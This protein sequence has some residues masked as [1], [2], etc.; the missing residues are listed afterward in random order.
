MTCR[1]YWF[2]C[3]IFLFSGSVW[4][5]EASE[6][7]EWTVESLELE[8]SSKKIYD[9][10]EEAQKDL[11]AQLVVGLSLDFN[12][13]RVSDEI[14]VSMGELKPILLQRIVDQPQKLVG[15]KFRSIYRMSNYAFDEWRFRSLLGPAYRKPSNDEIY[16]LLV[17]SFNLLDCPRFE[18][19]ERGPLIQAFQRVFHGELIG[20]VLVEIRP[21]VWLQ[22]LAAKLSEQSNSRVQL[23]RI[24]STEYRGDLVRGEALYF[25]LSKGSLKRQGIITPSD[26]PVMCLPFLP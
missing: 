25:E 2:V 10:V 22:E 1:M 18:S 16:Q 9:S 4:A 23:K 15:E 5:Q 14:T 3:S 13:N 6:T 17:G 8:D 24:E 19:V 20:G 12:G 7:Y 26:R 11:S 21:D